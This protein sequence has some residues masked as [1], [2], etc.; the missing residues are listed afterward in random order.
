[1]T[2]GSVSF[3][4]IIHNSLNVHGDD[5][6]AAFVGLQEEAVFGVVVEDI[7]SEGWV[8]VPSSVSGVRS[9]IQRT[10]KYTSFFLLYKDT[11]P[12]HG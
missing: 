11:G 10:V 1:M 2:E 7:L 12:F 8:S 6:P 9:A 5:G 4:H 3:Q